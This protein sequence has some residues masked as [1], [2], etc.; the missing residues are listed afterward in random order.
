MSM[1]YEKLV[2]NHRDFNEVIYIFGTNLSNLDMLT[3]ICDLQQQTLF[4]TQI[5]ISIP[6]H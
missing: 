1:K 2:I 4:L 6:Q 5:P 3:Y